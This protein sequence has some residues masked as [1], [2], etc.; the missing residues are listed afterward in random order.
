MQAGRDQELVAVQSVS[1]SEGLGAAEVPQV[2]VAAAAGELPASPAGKRYSLHLT[3]KI[4]SEKGLLCS[5]VYS[6][7]VTLFAC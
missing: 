2:L 1:L 5:L 7:Y 3:L 6:W 4:F